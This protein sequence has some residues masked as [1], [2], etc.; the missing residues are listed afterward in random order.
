MAESRRD[1]SALSVGK[2]AGKSELLGEEKEMFD[3]RSFLKGEEYTSTSSVVAVEHME[4]MDMEEDDRRKEERRAL[5]SNDERAERFIL[6]VVWFMFLEKGQ[7]GTWPPSLVWCRLGNGRAVVGV[8]GQER[9][10]C[11]AEKWWW[12][13]GWVQVG[14]KSPDDLSFVRPWSPGRFALKFL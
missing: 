14:R 10:K 4:A 12:F 2:S 8:R 1:C 3:E 13:A 11:E 5:P 9:S 7:A 6:F